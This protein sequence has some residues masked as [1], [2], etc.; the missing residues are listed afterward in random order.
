MLTDDTE[1]LLDRDWEKL[2]LA[3]VEIVR[4]D[5]TELLPA[6]DCSRTRES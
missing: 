1:V 4:C 3:F 2:K 6:T 5:C